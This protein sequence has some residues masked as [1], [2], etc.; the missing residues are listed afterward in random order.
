SQAPPDAPDRD[1]PAPVTS[2]TSPSDAKIGPSDQ[3]SEPAVAELTPSSTLKKRPCAEPEPAPPNTLAVSKPAQS[4]LEVP[5]P[6][7]PPPQ[8]LTPVALL[9]K[10]TLVELASSP[11]PMTQESEWDPR[12]EWSVE[13]AMQE[14]GIRGPQQKAIAAAMPE[15]PKR[16][17]RYHGKTIPEILD[18][19]RA[20]DLFRVVGRGSPDSCEKFLSAWKAWRASQRTFAC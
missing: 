11:L 13:R 5:A 7:S 3:P 15:L 9:I 1:V 4:S 19:I 12:S 16:L 8:E 2:A 14:L 17:K 10:T 6:V 20:A 18:N